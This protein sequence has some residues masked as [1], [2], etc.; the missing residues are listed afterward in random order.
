MSQFVEP[1]VDERLKAGEDKEHG[2]AQQ[3]FALG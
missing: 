2:S 1:D 3:I